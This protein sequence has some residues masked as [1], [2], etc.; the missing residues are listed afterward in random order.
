MDAI[1]VVPTTEAHIEG[2]QRC[3]D[4]VAR[5]RRWLD[6]VEGPPLAQSRAFVNTLLAGAGV[7]FVALDKAGD[8]AGWC[9]VVRDDRYDLW[10][11]DE[12]WELDALEPAVLIELVRTNVEELVD[13]G[14][15]E[16]ALDRQREGRE[17]LREVAADLV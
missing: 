4:A 9:D 15:W 11:G 5:E 3:V 13:P 12:S 2:S 6:F 7:Q 10:L 8:V 16:A 17:R 14:P 1:L